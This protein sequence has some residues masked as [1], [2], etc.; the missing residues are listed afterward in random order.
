MG[1]NAFSA[2]F[3]SNVWGGT[4][5]RQR[6]VDQNG[7][8]LLADTHISSDPNLSYLGPKWPDSPVKESE[9]ERVNMAKSPSAVAKGVP[10]LIP[11][12]ASLGPFSKGRYD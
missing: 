4:C 12:R 2:L 6:C 5:T 1:R 7:V 3:A 8:T 11:P 9:H 10:V